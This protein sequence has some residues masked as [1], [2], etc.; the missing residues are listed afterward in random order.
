MKRFLAILMVLGTPFLAHAQVDDSLD[1]DLEPVLSEDIN[2]DSEKLPSSSLNSDVKQ[3]GSIYIVN[4]ASSGAKA[5]AK[6]EQNDTVNSSRAEA[7]KRSRQR[8]ELETELKATEKIE[9]S[10]LSDE[11]RRNEVLFGDRYKDLDEVDREQAPVRRVVREIREEAP[12]IIVKERE[13]IK[14]GT[15]PSSSYFFTLVGFNQF[16]R[17]EN[18]Q[19]NGALGVGMGIETSANFLVEGMFQYGAYQ[20][21]FPWPSQINEYSA[22]G[23]MKYQFGSGTIVPLV[24]AAISYSYRTYF[25]S[26]NIQT[27]QSYTNALDAAVIGGAEFTITDSFSLGTE[28]RYFWNITS[29]TDGYYT[30]FFPNQAP[31]DTFSHYILALTGRY[32]F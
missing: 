16:P 20:S 15:P 26:F 4:Q 12:A 3:K 28:L 17:A 5:N 11:R 7:L 6:T 1:L 13:A 8:A 9:E 24:G 29:Q 2:V 23:A 22:V 25:D 31:L 19:G 27:R 10:R 32:N 18:I 14:S 21:T 30:I